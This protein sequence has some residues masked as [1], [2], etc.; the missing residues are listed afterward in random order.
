MPRAPGSE[1]G[2]GAGPG[3]G[4]GAGSGA[5]FEAGPGAGPGA[6]FDAADPRLI[7]DPAQ[8]SVA[9]TPAEAPRTDPTR[10]AWASQAATGQPR[11]TGNLGK[12]GR[13]SMPSWDEIVFGART[14][15]DLA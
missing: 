5:G 10:N 9:D 7:D 13:A 2:S 15:D 12:R 3:A 6:G 4:I 11:N 1:A 8:A 14:D